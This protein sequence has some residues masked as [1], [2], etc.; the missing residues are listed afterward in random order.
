MEV[1][2]VLGCGFTE[3]IYQEALEIE[4]KR[5][6]IP[7]EREKTFDVAYKGSRLS[8]YYRVDFLCYG[9]IVLELKAVDEFSPEHIAQVVNYLNASG[10]KLGILINFSKKSLVYKRIPRTKNEEFE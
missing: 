10:M 7:H 2:N 9:K 6:G 5:R 4:L 3:P 1:H 8:K